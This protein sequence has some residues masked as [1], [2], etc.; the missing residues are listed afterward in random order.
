M[1]NY[2]P[3]SV[4]IPTVV[5]RPIDASGREYPVTQVISQGSQ[6][7]VISR[8]GATFG[9]GF[10]SARDSD[11]THPIATQ[12]RLRIEYLYDDGVSGTLES[13]AALTP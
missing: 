12:Y 9:C 11:V 4:T 5:I 10:G 2:G 7:T 13:V 8:G 6:P 1:I 3:V